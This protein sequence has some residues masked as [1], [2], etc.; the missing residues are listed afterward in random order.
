MLGEIC[1]RVRWRPYL[2]RRQQ[3]RGVRCSCL[4][5]VPAAATQLR[6]TVLLLQLQL[7]GI[8]LLLQLLLQGTVL[9]LQLR[10]TV[11]RWQ[12]LLHNLLMKVWGRPHLLGCS[13]PHLGKL[14]HQLPEPIT[15][16]VCN[17]PSLQGGML[18]GG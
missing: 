10:G 18:Q 12:L 6:G 1:I 9:L 11:L 5:P 4:F 17:R 15:V 2:E 14:L 7:Q 16:G 8:V 3:A 13:L